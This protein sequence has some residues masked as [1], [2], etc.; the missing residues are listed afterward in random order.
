MIQP[1]EVQ[2]LLPAK[3][4]ICPSDCMSCCSP[5]RQPATNHQTRSPITG[6]VPVV[7]MGLVYEWCFGVMGFEALLETCNPAGL[8]HALSLKAVSY[9]QRQWHSAMTA[10]YRAAH[11]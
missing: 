8:A 11:V 2:Y 6:F 5:A 3:P 4:T 1:A 9:S 7:E 10:T